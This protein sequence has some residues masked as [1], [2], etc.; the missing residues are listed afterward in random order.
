MKKYVF[1]LLTFL[2]F[3]LFYISESFRS[4]WALLILSLAA[5]L[6]LVT[7]FFSNYFVKENFF[8]TNGLFFA[9][10]LVSAM[11]NF[12]VIFLSSLALN[13]SSLGIWFSLGLGALI[14]IK[15]F[16]KFIKNL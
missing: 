11:M 12:A 13:K 16:I 6:F 15:I 7:F 14:I 5:T 9:A 3:V 10:L 8:L 1:L 2:S 4:D